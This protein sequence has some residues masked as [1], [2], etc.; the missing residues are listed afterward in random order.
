MEKEFAV[1]VSDAA[2]INCGICM[3]VCPIRTL[4]MAR[5]RDHGPE[6]TF[7]R[8]T[9][10]RGPVTDWMMTVPI[11]VDHCNGCTICVRECPTEAISIRQVGARPA[12]AAR[13]GPML[14]E[15]RDLGGR[16]AP[17]ASYTRAGIKMQEPREAHDPWGK[18]VRWRIAK[19]VAPW[20]VWRTWTRTGDGPADSRQSPKGGSK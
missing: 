17:L 10:A 15:P 18:D 6:A 20:Q 5:A 12:F 11:Q 7:H 9:P 2:C 14:A 1:T 16:W 4:D 8:S 13:P 19:R 3:D